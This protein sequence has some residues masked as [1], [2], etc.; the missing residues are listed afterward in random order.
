MIKDEEL[1]KYL[2]KYLSE[3]NYNNLLA[4]LKS[5]PQNI[6]NRMYTSYLENNIVYQGDGLKEM[7]FAD[8]ANIEKG[9]KKVN[10]LILSNTCDMD[11]ANSRPFPASMMYAP[12]ISLANYTSMLRIQGINDNKIENNVLNLKQQKITQILFLPANSQIDDS[13]VFLDRI[14]HVD[15]RYV[16]RDTLKEKRLF[17]LS[18]YGFY[19]LIFK[20][21]VHFS[22]I[23]EK[24]NR[25]IVPQ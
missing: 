21:S 9:I 2:P 15:N 4:E 1:R 24:V 7:P 6:D 13:V 5:Y 25:G 22:R 20:L 23:Q 17:S 8:M 18:D 10:C 3:E 12:I 14:Q 11:L 16:N 19:M